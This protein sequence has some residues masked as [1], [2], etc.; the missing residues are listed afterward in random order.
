[1]GTWY[2]NM[3]AQAEGGDAF[4]AP[5]H[6]AA[7]M[8]ARDA[9]RQEKKKERLDETNPD[10]D[11]HGFFKEFTAKLD[12]LRVEL[13][14]IEQA[15]SAGGTDT[16]VLASRLETLVD[17]A[18]AVKDFANA[19]SH[20]L[21]PFDQRSMQM[22]L[23][24]FEEDRASAQAR[25]VPRKKFAF[26]RKEKKKPAA[27]NVAAAE[28]GSRH[29]SA[30]IVDPDGERE[31]MKST[32]KVEHDAERSLVGRKDT[33]LI[34]DAERL[35][36]RDFFIAQCEGCT[37]LLQGRMGALRME[38]VR[39]CVIMTGPVMG[40]CHVE[41]A[42]GTTFHLA[43]QQLRL[44]DSTGCD[45]YLRS[46]SDP[47]IEDC[48]GLRFAPYALE[49]E[50]IATELEKAGLVE[51]ECSDKW[52]QVKDFKW[53]RQQQSPNWCILPEEERVQPNTRTL[54]LI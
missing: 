30:T 9:E 13:A 42:E 34:V 7:K 54:G 16:A 36:G 53:L 44:H 22:K 3:T 21:P 35:A 39:N 33:T 43:V 50:G 14:D 20:Y 4:N 17:Q 18:Q 24:K 37:I 2:C 25:L 40:G 27:A 29:S 45:F 15:G 26:K 11:V 52:C 49:F 46:R 51:A 8:A 5:E 12:G 47:I 28:A 19:G 41:G 6:L 38:R 32:G 48:T 23:V 1:M 10:E 31:A